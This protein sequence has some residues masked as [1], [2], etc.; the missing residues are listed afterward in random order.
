MATMAPK[1]TLD[2][3]EQANSWLTRRLQWAEEQ[4]REGE[5]VNLTLTDENRLLKEV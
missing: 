5:E 1:D 3:L 4:V 2:S